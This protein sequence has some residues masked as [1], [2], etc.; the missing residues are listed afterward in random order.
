[1]SDLMKEVTESAAAYQLM[2]QREKEL[3]DKLAEAVAT[4]HKIGQELIEAGAAVRQ[5]LTRMQRAAL[6]L[7]PSTSLEN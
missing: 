5:A 1:M 3:H 4:Q 6:A 7:D 2:V